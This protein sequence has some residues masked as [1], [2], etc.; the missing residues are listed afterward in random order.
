MEAPVRNGALKGLTVIDLTMMLAGPYCTMVL[1]DQGATV[2]KV[3]PLDEGD[4]TRHFHLP[5]PSLPYG[6]YFQSINRNKLSIAIDLKS[7]R[8]QEVLRR[9]VQGADVLVENYRVGVMERLGLSYEALSRLNPKLVYAAVR[10]F[11]DPRTGASPYA[12]WPSFD[13]IAQAMGGVAGITGEL[14]GPPVKVGPGVGDIVP[15][16]F[17][18]VAIL[19][20]VHNAQRTG[21]GQFV[22][23]AMYDG[24][25]AMCERIVYQHSYTGEVPASEGNGHPLLC[26]FGFFPARDGWV[27][28]ACPK[29]H[30][31]ATLATIIGGPELA[32]DPRYVLNAARRERSDEVVEIVGRWTRRLTK[33]E[34][35][36]EL[37][38]K[39]PFGPVNTVEDIFRDPHVRARGMLA[40]LDQPGLG[41]VQVAG[42]PIRMTRTQGG[43]ARRGPLLGEDTDAILRAAGFAN[44]DIASLRESGVVQ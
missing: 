30:F 8:G 23:V 42:T 2:I 39:I 19:A 20:A 7:G 28:I 14:N 27:S 34:L 40:Q 4:M 21:E 41:P 44:D 10:G 43:V 12:D 31:W 6:G 33:A 36:S 11:G 25:L 5:D 16:L 22:D 24:V 9:L 35:T 15:A 1:G 3:E 18:T 17:A 29:D 13:V 38:G 37:G 26:P 32:A